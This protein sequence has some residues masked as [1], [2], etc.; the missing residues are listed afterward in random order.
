M[1]IYNIVS[2][3]GISFIEAE[4]EVIGIDH[5]DLDGNIAL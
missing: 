1:K 2:Y 4:G 3:K 5:T